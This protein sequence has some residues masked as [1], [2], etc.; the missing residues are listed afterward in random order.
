LSGQYDQSLKRSFQV[1]F[2]DQNGP[3][4]AGTSNGVPVESEAFDREWAHE[5]G[6]IR[7]A[8]IS[9]FL[10]S[11]LPLQDSKAIFFNANKEFLELNLPLEIEKIWDILY[12]QLAVVIR[13]EIF[14]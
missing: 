9:R 12:P 1:Y 6:A 5:I 3:R 4:N 11:S 8:R 14:I 2:V 7:D 10:K 13:D